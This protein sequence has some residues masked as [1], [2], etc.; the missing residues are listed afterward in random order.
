MK[1][2]NFYS[3]LYFRDEISFVSFCHEVTYS[4]QQS[5]VIDRLVRGYMV[6]SYLEDGN[7]PVDGGVYGKSITDACIGWDNTEKLVLDLAERV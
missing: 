6:E 7:Q 3:C 1:Y 2:F 5:S 4:C